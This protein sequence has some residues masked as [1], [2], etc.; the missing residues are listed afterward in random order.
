MCSCAASPR[1]TGRRS[2][3]RTFQPLN[4]PATLGPLQ[5]L[6]CVH[7]PGPLAATDDLYHPPSN[8]VHVTTYWTTDETP[9]AD[10]FPQ[11]RLVD[12]AGQVW[13]DKLERGNDAIH[14]WPTS[15]WIPGEVVRVDSDV[16]LN[17]ITPPGRYR[18]VVGLP[19]GGE[20][21]VCGEVEIK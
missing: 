21:V 3:Q 14:M 15:R 19:E 16:N 12:Q 17:P 8:W 7:D 4:P 18:L 11:V 10:V 20:S 9:S 2:Y 1:A 13:G 6:A 5:L